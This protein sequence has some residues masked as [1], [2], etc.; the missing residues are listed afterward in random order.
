LS[1]NPLAV[2]DVQNLAVRPSFRGEGNDLY[3]CGYVRYMDLFIK[4]YILGF[5]A[6]YDF[7]T[8]R[9]VLMGDDRYNYDREET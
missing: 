8:G 3:F 9:F 1:A 7:H 4:R 5:C 6:M 2:I